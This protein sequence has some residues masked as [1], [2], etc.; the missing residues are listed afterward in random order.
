MYNKG[1]MSETRKGGFAVRETTPINQ[2]AYHHPICNGVAAVFKCPTFCDTEIPTHRVRNYWVGEAR[3]KLG[4]DMRLCAIHAEWYNATHSNAAT[5][6][7]VR[8]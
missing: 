3:R 5:K 7:R 6:D 2:C 8:L 1:V 4:P